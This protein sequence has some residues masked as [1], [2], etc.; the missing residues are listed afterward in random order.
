MLAGTSLH[1]EGVE[2]VISTSEG[3]V[4]GHLTIRLDAV[5]EA[6]ELPTGIADLAAS[7]ANVDGDALTLKR[8]MASLAGFFKRSTCIL[9][10]P[11]G[12]S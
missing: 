7:L 12:K 5:L 8:K 2:G 11:S 9:E 3:L 4:R 1:E 6:V 10:W